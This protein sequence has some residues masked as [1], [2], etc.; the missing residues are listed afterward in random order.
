MQTLQVGDKISI[1][2]ALLKARI[3]M[4]SIAEEQI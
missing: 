1:E 2:N 3:D 4:M